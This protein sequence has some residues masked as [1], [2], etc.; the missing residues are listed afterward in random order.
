MGIGVIIGGILGLLVPTPPT[1]VPV[2]GQEVKP[3]NV[4]GRT[5][6]DAVYN[7]NDHSIVYTTLDKNNND[8]I[9][10]NTMN[11]IKVLLY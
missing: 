9:I 11:M 8:W 1:Q 10:K 7:A 2:T 3:I 6:K 5:V 4:Q